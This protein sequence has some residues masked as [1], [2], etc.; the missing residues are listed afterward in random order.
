MTDT[1]KWCTGALPGGA[2]TH[3]EHENSLKALAA[4]ALRE[5]G[6]APPPTSGAVDDWCTGASGAAGA[7]G[8]QFGIKA[9]LKSLAKHM[10]IPTAVVDSLS[11]DDL[12]ATAEQVALCEGRL[13]GNG[14]PLAHSLLVF[15]LQALAE[16][17]NA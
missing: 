12:T 15:Y 17:V 2:P 1:T 16:G 6:H 8:A 11:A 3:Q 7:R 9:T 5:S 14:N 4:N 10:G 13:D